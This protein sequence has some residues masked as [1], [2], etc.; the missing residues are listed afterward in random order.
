[1]HIEGDVLVLLRDAGDDILA[2][3]E[4][5][6]GWVKRANIVL[7]LPVAST[8]AAR[9]PTPP[10]PH[11]PL[12]PSAHGNTSADAVDSI[13]TGSMEF[14]PRAPPSAQA[15]SKARLLGASLKLQTA[16][17][18]AIPTPP[19]SPSS[20]HQQK[21]CSVCYSPSAASSSS[22]SHTTHAASPT[23]RTPRAA[24]A[25]LVPS[26]TEAAQPVT[27]EGPAFRL[28]D[29]GPMHSPQFAFDATFLDDSSFP[30][31]ALDIDQ[32]FSA[33][34]NGTDSGPS[35][36]PPPKHPLRSN[37]PAEGD[38]EAWTTSSS[39]HGD[40]HR[41][42][43][44][45]PTPRDVALSL[46]TRINPPTR[47]SSLSRIA[48]QRPPSPPH[49]IHRSEST[50]SMLS[51]ES[52]AIGG[53]VLGGPREDHDEDVPSSTPTPELGAVSLSAL[54]V[55]SPPTPTAPLP[56]P[57]EATP[58]QPPLRMASL[59][60]VNRS[61][62]V[63]VATVMNNP[64][65][66]HSLQV[67]TGMF[68]AGSR[69]SEA[70]T[71]P[72]LMEEEVPEDQGNENNKPNPIPTE[73]EDVPIPGSGRRGPRTRPG[74]LV[75][76]PDPEEGSTPRL[77]GELPLTARSLDTFGGHDPPQSEEN[78][79]TSDYFSMARSVSQYS[80][81]SQDSVPMVT[82]RPADWKGDDELL[83]PTADSTFSLDDDEESVHGI[84]G[85]ILGDISPRN[86][87]AR[88]STFSEDER[89]LR[90]PSPSTAADARSDSHNSH[91]V[92]DETVLETPQTGP[93]ETFS[94]DDSSDDSP[95]LPYLV[96]V[97]SIQD[98]SGVV[99]P[100]VID[101]QVATPVE[102][103]Q[104]MLSPIPNSASSFSIVHDS[105]N[106][107]NSI[108][109]RMSVESRAAAKAIARGGFYALG[110]SPQ[111][112]EEQQQSLRKLSHSIKESSPPSSASSSIK[113]SSV[114]GSPALILS[115]TARDSS[116]RNSP[117]SAGS[118]TNSPLQ[119]SFKEPSP[120]REVPLD[121]PLRLPLA[122]PETLAVEVPQ[123]T[124][125]P[126][127][128]S[129]RE[130]PLMAKATIDD[131][132]SSQSPLAVQTVGTNTAIA[133][134]AHG[135]GES[136]S[137]WASQTPS[138]G[139]SHSATSTPVSES[140]STN[141]W[142]NSSIL[143]S[144][145]HPPNSR[146]PRADAQ[147][148]RGMAL[149]GHLDMGGQVPPMPLEILR[150]SGNDIGI[151]R[152]P[153]EMVPGEHG[154]RDVPQ[155]AVPSSQPTPPV[156]NRHP[157]RLAGLG[158]PNGPPV[159]NVDTSQ[160]SSR[161]PATNE[162]LDHPKSLADD[163][164]R[165]VPPPIAAFQA[166]RHPG[167][168]RP[169]VE[170][171]SSSNGPLRKPSL[172]SRAV[173]ADDNHRMVMLPSALYQ[174]QQRNVTDA[175]TASEPT[176]KASTFSTNGHG[177]QPRSHSTSHSHRPRAQANGDHRPAP[178]PPSSND[179]QPS[180]S[181]ALPSRA[182]S[183][184][185]SATIAKSF[186]KGRK[187]FDEPPPLPAFHAP[188]KSSFSSEGPR[189]PTL[190]SHPSSESFASRGQAS[191]TSYDSGSLHSNSAHHMHSAAVGDSINTNSFTRPSHP[192]APGN[193]V[194]SASSPRPSFSVTR[195]ASL[196]MT[197]MASLR[198]PVSHRDFADPTVKTD[199][200]EFEII[201]PHKPLA[202]YGNQPISVSDH[203]HGPAMT[204][205]EM[206]S[207]LSSDD[208][209]PEMDEWGFLKYCAPT[210][211]IF[212]SRQSPAEV[213]AAEQKWV[214]RKLANALVEVR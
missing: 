191:T 205:A 94:A 24:L 198:P 101:T 202:L 4:G 116:S 138:P 89:S 114:L 142:N 83:T 118:R 79:R 69:L 3:C 16:V 53:I 27:P 12:T 160:G 46:A 38:V 161:L 115:P 42:I 20:L 132:P 73:D 124:P 123:P 177:L 144:A 135:N 97:V 45:P 22:S 126:R 105:P 172:P 196:P 50:S 143:P 56:A 98:D 70:P 200:M 33:L 165:F 78:L 204:A 67:D 8:S 23:A 168:R 88:S 68:D 157:A 17:P 59:R 75:L 192:F 153:D 180:S 173:S 37:P 146:S 82:L 87:M 184:S 188:P 185:F 14:V 44:V 117:L 159:Q 174:Q 11:K 2:Y 136:P 57:A 199:G 120:L 13:N 154:A 109:S 163:L 61:Q 15:S 58:R 60:S 139:A 119:D 211:Q 66:R 111:L 169:P 213:R 19:R 145:R 175:S 133:R 170:A 25:L 167:P 128:S 6:V 122:A 104:A 76:T 48:R 93:R 212:Q 176:P 36:V 209:P 30:S 147:R 100:L 106:S 129:L 102:H 208:A 64:T 151:G 49:P 214:C 107:P 164:K 127:Q 9:A 47:Q 155:G 206:F 29:S 166:Q 35:P 207:R 54:G 195:K 201:Q 171:T 182:R 31:P 203:G 150:D 197:T 62:G 99:Q 34:R 51:D 152:T 96:R 63:P 121:S 65:K 131:M 80:A 156:P 90:S 40:A 141:P 39:G 77:G 210:P 21:S 137:S 92:S 189:R 158:V 55:Y 86:S 32:T 149:L 28:R 112:T 7:D 72:S 193:H 113:E 194:R 162:R 26:P 5:E 140:P 186:G 74:M 41:V 187:S 110:H 183:R 108:D 134:D 95:S 10:S 18:H 179:H 181:R 178:P 81:Y 148:R 84:T 130:A 103:E 91:T 52:Y 85:L 43:P 1:M 125:L 190:E 71:E